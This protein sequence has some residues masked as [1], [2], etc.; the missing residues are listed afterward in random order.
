[1]TEMLDKLWIG[2]KC[3]L[4]SFVEDFKHEE[5]GAAE[6][7]AILLVIVVLIVVVAVFKDKLKSLVDNVF[8]GAEDATSGGTTKLTTVD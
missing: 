1:M 5:K 7:V 8:K 6:I 2:A 3:R 4:N